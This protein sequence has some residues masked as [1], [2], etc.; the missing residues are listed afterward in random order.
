MKRSWLGRASFRTKPGGG[1]P[2]QRTEQQTRHLAPAVVD[3]LAQGIADEEAGGEVFRQGLDDA[4]FEREAAVDDL[5][6]EG[7]R[8]IEQALGAARQFREDD[9]EL[10]RR[11]GLVEHVDGQALLLQEVEG[12]VDAADLAVVLGAVLHMVDHLE[13]GAQR[14]VGRP[15][16]AALAMHVQH[17]AADR[18]RRI[19]AIVHQLVPIRGARFGDVAAEGFE[20]IERVLVGQAPLGEHAAQR[21]AFRRG[22]AFAGQAGAHIFEQGELLG[23]RGAG[24]V[25]DVVGGARE[26]VESE[27]RRAVP[28]R[29]QHR[30]DGKILVLMALAGSE[31]AHVLP[32]ACALP[33]HMPPRPRQC[34]TAESSVKTA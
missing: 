18:H 31:I 19:A 23:R 13:R 8:G 11:L 27:N 7:P 26:T 33:F 15:G 14:V 6:G 5:G 2:P 30:R 32:I 22:V 20:K 28:L 4:D 1:K 24:M 10:R 12:D 3:A 17:E 16:G 21:D 9:S 29:D 25:G 34:W